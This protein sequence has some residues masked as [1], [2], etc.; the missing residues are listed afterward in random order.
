MKE[1]CLI[2][3]YYEEG[4]ADVLLPLDENNSIKYIIDY[5]AN[6]TNSKIIRDFV[7]S[8]FDNFSISALWRGR[9]ILITDELINNSI[10][11]GSVRDDINRCIISVQKQQDDDTFMISVEVHDTGTKNNQTVSL[12]NIHKKQN[13]K[14]ENCVYMGKRGRGL[15]YITDKIVDKMTF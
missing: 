5:R 8:I 10:E 15:F 12:E 13:S 11:H 6:Y 4:M 3:R 9:F 2:G 7:G 1:F 14:E